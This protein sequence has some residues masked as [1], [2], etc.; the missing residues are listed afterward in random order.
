MTWSTTRTAIPRTNRA[1]QSLAKLL[2]CEDV[3]DKKHEGVLLS[4]FQGSWPEYKLLRS[5][6][7]YTKKYNCKSS[8]STAIPGGYK[9][10][11]QLLCSFCLSLCRS[12]CCQKNTTTYDHLVVI[13]NQLRP[14]TTIM[15]N[16]HQIWPLWHFGHRP[17]LSMTIMPFRIDNS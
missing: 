12:H 6:T 16:Y 3:K 11:L 17:H 14:I 5:G 4:Q 10:V 8:F 7:G 13:Y 1:S 9:L 2:L 15:T